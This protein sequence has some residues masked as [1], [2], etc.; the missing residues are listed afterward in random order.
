M[1]SILIRNS[2]IKV[3]KLHVKKSSLTPRDSTTQ[4]YCLLTPFKYIFPSKVPS[5]HHISSGRLA[6]PTAKSLKASQ[7]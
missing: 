4:F 2:L 6:V 3:V 5:V 7:K 1:P